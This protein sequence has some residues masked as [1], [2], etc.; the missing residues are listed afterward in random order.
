M[1]IGRKLFPYPV[2]N[3]SKNVNCYKSSVYELRC[4]IIQE[5][6]MVNLNNTYINI[7]ND[8]IKEMLN[9]G[10]VKAGLVVECSSTIYRELFDIGINPDTITIPISDLREKVEISCFIYAN[11]DIELKSNDFLNEYEGY[12][13]KL[14][15]HDII[16]IDDGFT[17]KIDYDSS[18]DKKLASIFS[19]I[20]SES[21]KSMEVYPK[22]KKIEIHLPSVTYDYY[23]T[24]KAIEAFQN[25]FFAI[26]TIPALIFSLN[27]LKQEYDDLDDVTINHSWF[28]SIMTSYNKNYGCELNSNSFEQLDVVSVSQTIMNNS[29]VKAVND[30]FEKAIRG[31]EVDYD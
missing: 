10:K 17:T 23:F 26:I 12:S 2:L 1:R 14:E 31:G 28:K 9:A 3:N 7:N 27:F 11:T 18:K 4:E 13:F 5:E 16:A 8:E 21:A 15:K 30:I 6:G 22:D 24:L 25:E 29:I 20:K 19:V